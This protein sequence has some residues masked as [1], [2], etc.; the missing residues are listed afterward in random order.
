MR[1]ISV[2]QRWWFGKRFEETALDFAHNLS[3][4][5]LLKEVKLIK[6]KQS[7]LSRSKRD[8]ILQRYH[9]VKR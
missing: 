8:A 5:D 3:V 4:N 9:S 6:N 2:I 1:I 7:K